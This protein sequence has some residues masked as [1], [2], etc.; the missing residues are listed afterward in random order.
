M[1]GWVNE[2]SKFIVLPTP[3]SSQVGTQRCKLI[4]KNEANDLATTCFGIC[5]EFTVPDWLGS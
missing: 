4:A 3:N 5:P 1:H 2:G